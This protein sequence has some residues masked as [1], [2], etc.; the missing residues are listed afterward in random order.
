MQNL[1]PRLPR[2]VQD[3]FNQVMEDEVYGTPNAPKDGQL[4]KFIIDDD[5]EQMISPLTILVECISAL[6]KGTHGLG[7][8]TN[9]IELGKQM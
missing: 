2:M 9:R 5:E 3:H 1:L 8:F 4:L 6:Y 7:P